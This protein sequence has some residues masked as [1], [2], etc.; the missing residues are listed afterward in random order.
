[1]G[2]LA[3]A[4]GLVSENEINITEHIISELGLNYSQKKLAKA[5]FKSGTK[6]LN[7][8]HTTAYLQT[9]KLTSPHLLASFF[10]YQ[11]RIIH[12]DPL[13]KMHQI[14]I[15]NQIKFNLRQEQQQG[16]YNPLPQNQLSNAY[17]ILGIHAKMTYPEMKKS[18]QK[19][20]GKHHPDRAKNELEK[21]KSEAYVKT[22]QKA[23][24]SVKKHHKEKV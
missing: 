16:S 18:Y 8:V 13:G 9:L 10:S 6:G 14:N 15:L 7:L 22:V 20:I 11:Q 4:D 2:Y 21:T 3:K 24:E 23:W 5:S 19:L 1:M 12:A 17:K